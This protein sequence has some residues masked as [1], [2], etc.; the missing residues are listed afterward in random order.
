M[1]LPVLLFILLLNIRLDDVQH[2]PLAIIFIPFWLFN[3]LSTLFAAFRCVDGYGDERWMS[4][5]WCVQIAIFTVFEV[6]LC[7][8]DMYP[9]AGITLI[10][11]CIPLYIWLAAW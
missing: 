6:L 5:M 11:A 8:H 1:F 9:D 4:F 10:K 3:C 7:V 2:I